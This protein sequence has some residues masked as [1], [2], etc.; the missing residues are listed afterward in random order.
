MR[1]IKHSLK[2]ITPDKIWHQ[3]FI[4]R[5]LAREMKKQFKRFL[6]FP[7]FYLSMPYMK[8]TAKKRALPDFLIIGAQKGGTSFFLRLLAQH[9][10]IHAPGPEVHYFDKEF[11]YKKGELWYRSHFP[12]KSVLS[13]GDLVG[14][15]TPD[16]L[17]FPNA[18]KRI[19]MD[20]PNAKLICLLRNPTE[21]AISNYFMAVRGGRESLPIMEALITEEARYG[22][23][24][25]GHRSYKRRGLYLEQIK[26]YENY[27]NKNKLLILSSEEFFANPQKILKQ[28]F[29]FLGVDETFVCPNLSFRNVGKNKVPVPSEVYEYLDK[30]FKPH[31]RRLYSY[32][33]RDFGW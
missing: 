23:S 19:Q 31:N 25:Y 20:L 6:N 12:L 15:K 32:L 14:E 26:R 28:V 2:R 1:Q 29:K 33:N 17:F 8:A 11:N 24:G 7:S 9:P 5:R 3:L 4:T 13:P 16:Y 18:A 30:Y 21:R 10:Q 27:F 22:S